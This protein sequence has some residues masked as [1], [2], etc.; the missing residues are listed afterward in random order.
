MSRK[1]QI[2][3]LFELAKDIAGLDECP[4]IH[5]RSRY[6]YLAVLRYR[7]KYGKRPS[8]SVIDAVRFMVVW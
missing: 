8:Q 1:E 2:A 3:A 4:E 7:S 5:D 6:T